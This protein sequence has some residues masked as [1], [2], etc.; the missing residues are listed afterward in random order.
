MEGATG[1]EGMGGI[2]VGGAGRESGL[3]NTSGRLVG[4]HAS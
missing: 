2:V 4:E 1:R 3:K